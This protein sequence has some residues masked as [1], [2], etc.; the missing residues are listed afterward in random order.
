MKIISLTWSLYLLSPYVEKIGKLLLIYKLYL[1]LITFFKKPPPRG[2]ETFHGVRR[3][4]HRVRRFS[5]GFMAS[6]PSLPTRVTRLRNRPLRLKNV[7]FANLWMFISFKNLRFLLVKIFFFY[8]W[9]KKYPCLFQVEY[10]KGQY[11]SQKNWIFFCFFLLSYNFPFEC[12]NY[13]FR[14]CPCF[15]CIFQSVHCVQC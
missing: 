14:N 15:W 6:C 5:T 4:F 8:F 10:T 1:Y 2:S 12:L 3:Q 9:V 7:V 13:G 11:L